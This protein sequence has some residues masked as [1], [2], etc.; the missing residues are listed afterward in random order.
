VN[1]RLGGLRALYHPAQ[2]SSVCGT[3]TPLRVSILTF[4]R[5]VA[6]GRVT[7]YALAGEAA[8]PRLNRSAEVRRAVD[9]QR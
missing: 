1:C 3:L 6:R 5:V 2:S 7:A 8:A 9:L 4:P